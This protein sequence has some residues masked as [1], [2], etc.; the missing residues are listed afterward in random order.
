M[1]KVIFWL[2]L[3][4]LVLVFRNL[5]VG[6]VVW[7]DAPHFYSEGLRELVGEP[8][9]WTNRGNTLGGVNMFLWMSPVMAVYGMLYKVFGFGS[10]QILIVLFY[11]PSLVL[12]ATGA[13]FLAR[14]WGLGRWAQVIASLAYALNTYYLLVVD[15][16]VVGLALAYGLF[17]WVLLSLVSLVKSVNYWSFVRALVMLTFL[18]VVDPRVL[19]IVA[20]TFLVA[21]GLTIRKVF[22]QLVFLSGSVV[23]LGSYWLVPLLKLGGGIAGLEVSELSLVRWSDAL[24]LHQPHWPGNI[25]GKVEAPPIYFWGVVLLV[26]GGLIMGRKKA[27]WKWG[28]CFL[29]FAFLAKGA[30]PPFGGHY[31]WVLENVPLGVIFRDSSKF[32]MPL[33]LMAGMIIGSGLEAVGKKWGYL[34]VSAYLIFLVYPA[35]GGEMNFVLSGRQHGG[36]ARTIYENLRGESGY[37]RTAWFPERGL[38]AFQT[39]EKP[40]IDAKE[41]V[42]LKPLGM[43]NV[44]SYDRFNYLNW[45][46]Y[47]DWFD[48]LGIKYLVFSGD[49]RVVELGEEERENWEKLKALADN[50]SNWEK[51][52]WGGES[53]VYRNSGVYPRIFGA[54]R[55]VAV[56]GLM[57]PERGVD[58]Q[59]FAYFEDG[60][61]DPKILEAVGADAAMIVFNKD[62]KDDLMMSLLQRYFVAAAESKNAD[63]ALRKPGDYLRYKY[64]ILINGVDYRDFDYGQGL[65]FSSVEGEKLNLELG[66]KG[67][68]RYVLAIRSFSREG[69]RAMR[70]R[71]GNYDGEIDSEIGRFG[72]FVREVELEEGKQDLELTSG[73]GFQAVNVAALI[74][75]EAWEEALTTQG[76][77]LSKFE[78]MDWEEFVDGGAEGELVEVRNELVGPLRY[79]VDLLSD[80]NW[81]VFTDRF[82]REWVLRRK[83]ESSGSVALYSMVN[84]FYK[85]EDWSE[86]E[87]FFEGQKELRRGGI[88][89]G[90]YFLGLAIVLL[91]IYPG[92]KGKREG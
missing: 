28:V 86:A 51:M 92:R 23:M 59:V 76:Q 1:R 18:M 4:V 56:V 24:T 26:F 14:H 70:Y 89:S 68:G 12:A 48:L 43:M 15:G 44:G 3:V 17:P 79:Q 52:D 82:S 62:D 67:A 60:M 29:L 63:W 75:A 32:Y 73:S 64:E 35:V 20:L 80:V 21:E 2:E 55:L 50:Q 30:S 37:F 22:L 16:G 41:L 7:G 72:W 6:S 36:E 40:A 38:L 53:L 31:T 81:I 61:F 13:V 39:E 10:E 71:L 58:G 45:D 57:E 47:D 19:L 69:S 85:P 74:P 9:A 87:V 78:S 34:L 90:V 25:F 83:R 11:L 42:N 54:R 27:V 66:G 8:L 65:A 91:W 84:G 77:Y 33:T 88:V 49:E 46:G 5:F